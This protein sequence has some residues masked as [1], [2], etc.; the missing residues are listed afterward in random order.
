MSLIDLITKKLKEKD[1]KI[2]SA[3]DLEKT[4]DDIISDL[5]ETGMLKFEN[6][7]NENKEDK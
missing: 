6:T 5:V 7:D 2:L 1:K 3:I 4:D